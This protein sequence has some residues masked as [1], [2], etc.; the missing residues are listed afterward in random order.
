[1]GNDQNE[2]QKITVEV[3]TL[4]KEYFTL[5]DR[6]LDVAGK[7]SNR[8]LS[9]IKPGDYE[10]IYNKIIALTDKFVL[11]QSKMQD[12]AN[13]NFLVYLTD[14]QKAFVTELNN[15]IYVLAKTSNLLAMIVELEFLRSMSKIDISAHEFSSKWKIY[16]DHCDNCRLDGIKINNLY[17][18]LYGQS[19]LT[20]S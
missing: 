4:L 18:K 1:M 17:Q 11:M 2:L 19:V 6:Y 15:Y 14:E 9:K 7:D 13:S 8:M 5:H 10:S 20:I 12:V 3:N 16:Q